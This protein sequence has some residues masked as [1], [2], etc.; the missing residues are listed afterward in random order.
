MLER[1]VYGGYSSF[2]G[3]ASAKVAK[4]HHFSPYAKAIGF[5]S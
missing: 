1:G 4:S 2:Y 5:N 3:T